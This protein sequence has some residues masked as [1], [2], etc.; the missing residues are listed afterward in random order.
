[1]SLV[2]IASCLVLLGALVQSDASPRRRRSPGSPCSGTDNPVV[3]AS[4]PACYAGEG[5]AQLE[6]IVIKLLN[7]TS[8]GTGFLELTGTGDEKIKCKD[9]LALPFSKVDTSQTLTLSDTALGD[10]LPSTVSIDFVDYCSVQDT[11]YGTVKVTLT[12]NSGSQTY[13]VQVTLARQDSCESA[14]TPAPTP[15]AAVT[16]N[17]KLFTGESIA[18]QSTQ[19]GPF[20]LVNIGMFGIPLCVAGLVL[21]I[22]SMKRSISTSAYTPLPAL[23]DASEDPV[24]SE[25]GGLEVVLVAP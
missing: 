3:D 1:M 22:R 11:F 19:T 24:A 9:S 4:D 20:T 15:A 7:F 21:G 16:G 18:R 14:A 17:V 10:C 2:R 5:T 6:D 25:T 23:V 8:D 12:G 13:T